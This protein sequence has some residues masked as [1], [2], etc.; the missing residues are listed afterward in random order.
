MTFSPA[1]L[2]HMAMLAFSALVAFSFTFGSLVANDIDPA[3]I[4]AIRFVIAVV[5]LALVAK[6][7]GMSLSFLFKGTWRWMVIG[8][9]MAGYFITMFEALALTTP[10]AT[11]AVFTLAPL[12][13]AC[14]GWVLLQLRTVWV[15]LSALCLG[16][17]GALW[18]IFRGDLNSLIGFEVGMGE[19]LFFFGTIAH[20]AVP[21][22]TRRLAP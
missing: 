19:V 12:M 6:A 3:V 13:A 15:T 8:G 16:A 5:T 1:I 17:A 4:T 7:L 9:L 14:F 20:A 2:G 21:A 22:V 10:L 11:A 18:V